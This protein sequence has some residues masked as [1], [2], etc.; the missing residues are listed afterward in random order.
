MRGS[1]SLK[2]PWRPKPTTVASSANRRMMEL[3]LH[4]VRLRRRRQKGNMKELLPIIHRM[5]S[6]RT[7]NRTNRIINVQLQ[8]M[9]TIS[10]PSLSMI[11]LRKLKRLRQLRK[12]RRKSK[13]RQLARRR[14]QR[15]TAVMT[16]RC[17]S[18][19]T[20]LPRINRTKLRW[21]R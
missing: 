7:S 11:L 10:N 18:S 20:L 16:T 6:L 4:A 19:M 14:Q 3:K 9:L 12:R 5:N 1:V 21:S 17:S 15:L 13:G 2:P 8:N